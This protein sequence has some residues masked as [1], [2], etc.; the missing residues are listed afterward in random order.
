MLLGG[1]GALGLALAKTD[2]QIMLAGII[3]SFFMNGTYAGVYAYTAEVFPTAVRTTGAGLASAIGRL[4]A[5][6][7]PVLV[8]YLYPKFGFLGVFGTTTVTL[9]LGALVVLVM[10]VPTRCARWK[11][12]RRERRNE[13]RA[14]LPSR[15]GGAGLECR[16]PRP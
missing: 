11:P 16:G 5:I 7:S 4:G 2:G 8:G 3:M 6:A 10:G 13:R 9:V 1:A 12:S 15:R 14:S